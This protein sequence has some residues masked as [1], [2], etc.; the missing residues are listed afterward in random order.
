M[1][2]LIKTNIKLN[3]SRDCLLYEISSYKTLIIKG[4]YK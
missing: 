1:V 3:I 2:I 4:M